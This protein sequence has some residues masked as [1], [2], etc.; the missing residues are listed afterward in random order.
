VLVILDMQFGRSD[1]ER[2][3]PAMLPYLREPH[4]HIALDPEFHWS[5]AQRPGVL[6]S[7]DGAEIN[8]AQEIVAQF[9]KDEGLGSKIMVVHQFRYDMITN[10]QVVRPHEGIDLVWNADGFGRPDEKLETYTAI[11]HD[12]VVQWPGTKLFY[13]QD[14][15]LW[16]EAT[17]LGLDPQPVF[18]VYQ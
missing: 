18:V 10:K 17:V 16:S 4:V 2:E 8:R 13:R 1:V 11:T 5:A 14:T 6:G 12:P 7:M 15:P 3:V 9:V